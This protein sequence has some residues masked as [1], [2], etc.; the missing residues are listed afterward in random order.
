M[1]CTVNKNRMDTMKRSRTIRVISILSLSAMSR[2]GLAAPVEPEKLDFG[3]FELASPARE[4]RVKLGPDE[5]EEV[6]AA[7]AALVA[8]VARRTGVTLKYSTYSSPVGGDVFVSTQPW[9][10][11]AAWFVRLKNNI[12]AIHGSDAEGTLRA[13]RA[14]TD[15]VRGL[16]T[17]TLAFA[18]VDLKSGP[19]PGDVFAAERARVE[20]ASSAL[21]RA[22]IGCGGASG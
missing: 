18:D 9:A 3:P 6:R 14:F 11:K 12:V 16:E 19:Q 10:A 7:V 17:P 13:V 20:A 22:G 4:A 5:T 1:T 8:D 21:S 15:F 2:C